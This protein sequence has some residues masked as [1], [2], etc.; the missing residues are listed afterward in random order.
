MHGQQNVKKK[1]VRGCIVVYV[2]CAYVGLINEQLVTT[3]GMNNVIIG[4]NSSD[5]ILFLL[6]T[7]LQC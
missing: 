6:N 1:Y 4:G 2:R 5:Q 7:M 3:H